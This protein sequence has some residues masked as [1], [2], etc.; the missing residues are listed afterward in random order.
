M[1]FHRLALTSL[2]ALSAAATFAAPPANARRISRPERTPQPTMEEP[3]LA[4]EW[5]S[6]RLSLGISV[7]KASVRHRHVTYDPTQG[8]NFLGNIND[9]E[10]HDDVAYGLVIRYVFTPW[11]ALEAA[12]DFRAD[13]DACNMDGDSC[14]GTVKL[15][16]WRVQAILSWPEESW[17]VRPWAGI[18][19]EN[20]TASFSHSP[21]WHYGWSSPEDYRR[22]GNS[23]REP[24]N[25]VTRTMSVDDPGLSPVFS[26]G[27]TAELHRH[28]QLDVFARWTDCDD[29]DA[30]FTR[31]VGRRR[32]HMLDGSFPAEHIVYGAAIRA[33][34]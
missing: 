9:M 15:R 19:V 25:G 26:A 31:T 33:V 23:S 30:E 1:T 18:G 34:F 10:E 13:L 2:V 22:Y 17:I 24:R 21:W 11:L 4:D 14:D 3:S 6:E 20:V 12:D 29:V 7:A 5:I 8:N 32:Y 27:I 16:S 28:V